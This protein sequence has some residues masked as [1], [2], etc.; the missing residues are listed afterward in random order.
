MDK[1]LQDLNKMLIGMDSLFGS[2]FAEFSKQ[3]Y[4]PYNLIKYKDGSYK[5]EIA[6]AGID[7]KDVNVSL[8]QDG[9]LTI[10]HVKKGPD[11][12]IDLDTAQY[13]HRGISG[14]NFERSFFLE[15]G[16]EVK[17]AEYDNGILS[18]YLYKTQDS[19]KVK[20]IEIN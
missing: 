17:A 9:K 13:L 18:I 20:N 10:A 7:K 19:N 14:R 3:Q 16:I 15:N 4:P 6:M 8:T 5:I 12:S 2:T 1:A 11:D